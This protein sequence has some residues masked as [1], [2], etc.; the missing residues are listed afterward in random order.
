M[1]F[2]TTERNYTSPNN[3]SEKSNQTKMT[4][5]LLQ[6]NDQTKVIRIR[7]EKGTVVSPSHSLCGKSETILQFYYNRTHNNTYTKTYNIVISN[8]IL[9]LRFET[10]EVR[11]VQND[12][13]LLKSTTYTYG[14]HHN[15]EKLYV[16]KQFIRESNQT[17]MTTFLLQSN[18]QTKIIKIR[19]EKGTVVSPSHSLYG[20]SETILQFYHNTTIPIPKLTTLS[21]QILYYEVLR[22]ETGEVRFVHSDIFC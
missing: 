3:L 20:K 18:D 5:F 15:R 17:K 7:I 14:L 22:F 8:F 13:C 11:L 9:L 21:F 6:S 19:I 1:D 2:I 12:I 10:V 16:P 4:T